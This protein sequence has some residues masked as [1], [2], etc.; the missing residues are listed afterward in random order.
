ML[1]GETA[2]RTYSMKG[3]RLVRA[4][5]SGKQNLV[6]RNSGLESGYISFIFCYKNEF[7][8]G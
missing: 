3:L 2:S 1:A 4:V 6:N 7:E 5:L 8:L